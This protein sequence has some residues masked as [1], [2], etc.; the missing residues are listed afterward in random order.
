MIGKIY[1]YRKK[2]KILKKYTFLPPPTNPLR[3]DFTLL[4]KKNR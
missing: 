3:E 2:K 4:G 1:A